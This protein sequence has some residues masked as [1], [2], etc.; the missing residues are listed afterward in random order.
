MPAFS[1]APALLWAIFKL[2]RGK[3]HVAKN[4]LRLGELVKIISRQQVFVPEQKVRAPTAGLT[5]PRLNANTTLE[6]VNSAA[7]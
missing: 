2:I 6:K 3:G 7:A 5:L 1:K 4:I